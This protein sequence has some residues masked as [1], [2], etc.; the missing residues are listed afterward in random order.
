MTP[1]ATKSITGGNAGGD[2][3]VETPPRAKQETT[4]RKGVGTMRGS[5]PA[6]GERVWLG[7]TPKQAT[8]SQGD[9]IAVCLSP[10]SSAIVRTIVDP[11]VGSLLIKMQI[12]YLLMLLC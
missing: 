7:A 2:A 9:I 5:M 11:P 3:W 8:M 1:R 6:A 12:I 10:V 4:P